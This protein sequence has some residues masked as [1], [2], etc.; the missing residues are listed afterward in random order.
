MN[1]FDI[2]ECEEEVAGKEIYQRFVKDP[3]T[4]GK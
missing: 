1:E 3:L 4:K 2:Q